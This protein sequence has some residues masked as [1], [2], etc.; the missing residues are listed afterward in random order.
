VR[1]GKEEGGRF[2]EEG[3]RMKKGAKASIGTA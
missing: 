1:K 2:K 3:R